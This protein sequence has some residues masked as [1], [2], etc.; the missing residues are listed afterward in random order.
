MAKQYWSVLLS[1]MVVASG[2]RQRRLITK[3]LFVSSGTI[4]QSTEI[5][6]QQ[7]LQ[8]IKQQEAKLIDVSIPLNATP[9]SEYYI[10]SKNNTQAIS[11]GYST[12]LTVLELLDFYTIEMEHFGWRNVARSEGKEELLFY[13][14]PYNYC[15]ISLRPN[16]DNTTIVILTTGLREDRV[17]I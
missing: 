7:L 8:Q 11:L 9:L 2:C 10:A 13:Q 1:I 14:K 6:K 3:S 15:A 5:E 12:S 4:S 17:A 16:L